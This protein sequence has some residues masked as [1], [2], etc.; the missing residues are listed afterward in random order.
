M[1]ET[2][3]N[4]GENV[5]WKLKRG[6]SPL[7]ATAVHDGHDLRAEVAAIMKLERARPP[8]RRRPVYEQL[9]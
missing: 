5:I 3:E 8:A 9:G 1:S 7:I 4:E 2:P 6:D